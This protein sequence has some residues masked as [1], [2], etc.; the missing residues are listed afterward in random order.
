MQQKTSP[1]PSLLIKKSISIIVAWLCAV[2]LFNFQGQIEKALLALLF[3]PGLTS[4]YV[5]KWKYN[6]KSIIIL[7]SITGSRVESGVLKCFAISFVVC[8]HFNTSNNETGNKNKALLFYAKGIHNL[9]T[10][11]Y[12]K[13]NWCRFENLPIS[14]SSFEHNML[15]IVHYNPFYLLRYA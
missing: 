8:F 14:T 3:G 10:K 5:Y 1:L 12:L 13:V 9:R 6:E 11:K 2:I 7:P 15:K 4:G